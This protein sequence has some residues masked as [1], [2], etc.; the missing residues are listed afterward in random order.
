[1]APMVGSGYIMSIPIPI[2]VR[3]YN[4]FGQ[5]IDTYVTRYV[6]DIV[7]RSVI[8]GGFASATIK[9]HNPVSLFGQTDA[10][11]Y[12]RLAEVFNRVQ[13]CDLR[14]MEICWEG[15]IEDSRRVSDGDG[16]ELGCLG[17]MVSATDIQRAMFYI[18]TGID[19]WILNTL[20]AETDV[21]VKTDDTNKTITATLKD[22][23]WAANVGPDPGNSALFAMWQR[24]EQVDVNIGR[25]DCTYKGGGTNANLAKWTMWVR[26]AT[27]GSG[28]VSTMD[29]TGCT[30]AEIRKG[31]VAVTDISNP[32]AKR[33]HLCI[34]LNDTTTAR[35]V[36]G[37]NVVARFSAP[38]VQVVR[39][40]ESGNEIF[41]AAEYA[42]PTVSV[43]QVVRDVLGR[44]LVSGWY[45][46]NHGSPFTGQVRST[47]A[48]I[49]ASSP[50]EIT[51]LTYWDGTTAADILNDLIESAAQDAYWAIW[52]TNYGATDQAATLS[53]YG[54]R[55]EWVKWPTSWGYQATTVDGF[56]SQ[57][58]GSDVYNGVN[59]E[60]QSNALELLGLKNFSYVQNAADSK[61]SETL[62]MAGIT[63]TR[64]IR[65]EGSTD[66][67]TS[68][69]ESTDLASSKG[70][71]TN[72]G[73]LNIAR[74]IYL[75]DN[76][77]LPQYSGTA[78]MLDPW[79]IRPGK[80]IRVIDVPPRGQWNNFTKMPGVW[81]DGLEGTIFRVVATEFSSSSGVCKLEL[82]EVTTWDVATQIKGS[83]GKSNIVVKVSQ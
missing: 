19:S 28:T 30:A 43:A 25:F 6:E 64:Y 65:R 13:I 58:S 34:G 71:T 7:F 52:E 57:P 3:I 29:A 38:M 44:F 72:S 36:A 78:R 42:N 8:P 81:P 1:M 18:D 50:V 23:T 12:N 16:W 31:N 15:R 11:S 39:M 9:L 73:T 46:N 55:F 5:T 32:A 14:T 82:D 77:N 54:A 66:A 74:P 27:T 76:G 2:G 47:D 69:N 24:G 22:Q 63:R 35:T 10:G 61:F 70:K 21:D 51:H 67:T 56:D 26:W 37:Q 17:T 79:A 68:A 83:A 20:A 62:R 45:T 40:D 4:N 33:I 53:K 60:F 75:F 48:F 49:D 41:T 80:M 59:Y